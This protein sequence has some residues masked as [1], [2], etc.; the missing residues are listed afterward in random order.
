M[1]TTPEHYYAA[2]VVPNWQDFLLSPADVRLGFN[3]AVSA[4]HMSDVLWEYR[5]RRGLPA[6]LGCANRKSFLMTL[7]ARSPQFVTVQTAATVYKH[8]YAANHFLDCG[9]PGAFE[10]IEAPDEGVSFMADWSENGA[11]RVRRRDGTDVTL[12]DAVE[13]VV[14]RVWPMMMWP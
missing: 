9:S 3:A 1:E 13:E 2:F 10:G 11:V 12:N 7:G 6:P 8:L 4:F 14:D 5:L